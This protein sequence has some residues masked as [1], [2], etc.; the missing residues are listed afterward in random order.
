MHIPWRTDYEPR[1]VI[2]RF[3]GGL[4]IRRVNKF[5][6]PVYGEDPGLIDRIR[7]DNPADLLEST[8]LRPGELAIYINYPELDDYN[9]DAHIESF[10][11]LAARRGV[12]VELVKVP[13]AHHTLPY[14][15]AAEMPSYRWIGGHILAMCTRAR[16]QTASRSA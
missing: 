9:F 8:D 12:T 10:A 3:Y 11:W 4:L 16:I 14:F 15:E 2:A 13:G 1:L 5:L 6:G 7:L